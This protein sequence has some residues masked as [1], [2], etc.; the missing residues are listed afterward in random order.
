MAWVA[1]WLKGCTRG[2]VS[3]IRGDPDGTKTEPAA[4]SKV[5]YLYNRGEEVK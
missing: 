4:V 1:S 2:I 5:L 3:P